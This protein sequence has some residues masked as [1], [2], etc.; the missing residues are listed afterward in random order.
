MWIW[1]RDH[2]HDDATFHP[3]TMQRQLHTAD[4]P[5]DAVLFDNWRVLHGR[6]AYTGHR[7]LA[8]GY[9]NREDYERRR[10]MLTRT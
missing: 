7:H 9:I 6:L 3:A 1:L 4:R 5:G 10:R 2:S 8:G